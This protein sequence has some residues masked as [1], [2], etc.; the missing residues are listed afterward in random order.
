MKQRIFMYLFVFSALLV[1]FQY[2]NSKRVFE[3]MDTKLEAHK[4][5]S[6]KSHYDIEV[7]SALN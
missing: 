5:K 2:A 3:D 6:E 7:K 4:I 1:L